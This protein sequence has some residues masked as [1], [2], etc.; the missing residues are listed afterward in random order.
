M[1]K[2]ARVERKLSKIVR[3]GAREIVFED[4]FV[5][6]YE[7]FYSLFHFDYEQKTISSYLDHTC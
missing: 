3:N 2:R 7:R 4:P 6:K 1:D 5:F